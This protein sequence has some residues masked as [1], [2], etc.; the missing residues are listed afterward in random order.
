MLPDMGKGMVWRVF[1]LGCLLGAVIGVVLAPS[2]GARPQTTAPNVF[3]N[4]HVTLTDTKVI[5][6]PKSAP[7]GSDARFI[8]TNKGTKPHSFTLGSNKLGAD[9]QSGFTRIVAPKHKEIL[10]LY[11]NARGALT[12]YGGATAKK[13]SPAMK[14][15]FLVGAQ[16]A[17]C[18]PDN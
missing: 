15:I 8:V 7:R 4:V 6:T 12:Y 11:L 16:C 5:L 18:V 3:V 1:S 9:L 14:G 10:L 13:S 2:A 17:E